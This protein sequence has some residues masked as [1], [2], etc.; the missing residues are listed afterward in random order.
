MVDCDNCGSSVPE[1]WRH[2]PRNESMTHRSLAW[3]CRRC[4]PEVPET[5]ATTSSN[6]DVAIADGGV[7][8]L[9]CPAC[10]GPTV[11]GQGLFDCRQCNWSGTR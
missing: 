5:V 3:L 8:S 10:G 9:A 1:V 7:R 4:H 2:R 6:A 11:D